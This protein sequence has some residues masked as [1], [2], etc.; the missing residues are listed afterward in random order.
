MKDSAK[1]RRYAEGK[2][3]LLSLVRGYDIKEI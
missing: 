1:Q 3:V 2:L